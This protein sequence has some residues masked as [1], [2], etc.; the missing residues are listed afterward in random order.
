MVFVRVV[1]PFFAV[2]AVLSVRRVVMVFQS[3]TLMPAWVYLSVFVVADRVK[4][5]I[6]DIILVLSLLL[7]AF[8][9]SPLLIETEPVLGTLKTLKSP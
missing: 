1:H 8:T 9:R 3:G 2:G 6:G 5:I 4:A 7:P